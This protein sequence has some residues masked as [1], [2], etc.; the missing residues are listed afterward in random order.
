MMIDD[1]LEHRSILLN[2]WSIQEK[3]LIIDIIDTQLSL[4]THVR[5]GARFQL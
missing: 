4:C 2:N 3:L 5:Q 1:D